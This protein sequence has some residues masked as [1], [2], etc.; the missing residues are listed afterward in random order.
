MD[1]GAWV[2]SLHHTSI[3]TT[4]HLLVSY[5]LPYEYVG[6]GSVSVSSSV[7]GSVSGSSYGS[8]SGTGSGCGP[9]AFAAELTCCFLLRFS[10]RFRLRLLSIQRTIGRVNESQRKH[11]CNWHQNSWSGGSWCPGLCGW[12]RPNQI[13]W[14]D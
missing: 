7:S 4:H 5:T 1:K 2:F 6:S 12:V 8:G 13:A 9:K 10:C 11:K 3:N 14:K